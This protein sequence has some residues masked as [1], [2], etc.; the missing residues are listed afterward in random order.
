[1]AGEDSLV[2]VLDEAQR[3]GYLGPASLDQQLAHSRA[4]ATLTASVMAEGEKLVDL[5]SGGGLPGLVLAT[6]LAAGS[7][8]LVESSKPRAAWLE[9]TVRRLG[10]E[11]HV[12]VLPIRAELLGRGDARFGFDVVTARSFGAPAVVAECAAPLLRLGG[13]LLVSEP[14]TG[15]SERWPGAGLARLGLSFSREEVVA[16]F[17]FAVLV[18]DQACPD[19]F[20]R[21]PGI[22]TKRPLFLAPDR[23]GRAG[24]CGT[25]GASRPP[26]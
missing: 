9:S 15:G 16:G 13:H 1:M 10:L 14:P 4:F 3:R 24:G 11:N 7:F 8:A 21:R 22:P 12:S 26:E 5:G 17:H 6:T 25:P 23:R 18:A 20:P 19:P 2:D